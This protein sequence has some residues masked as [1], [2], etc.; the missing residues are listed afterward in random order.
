MSTGGFFGLKSDVHEVTKL[1]NDLSLRE[2]LEGSYKCPTLGKEKG[3][4]AVNANEPIMQSV[5]KVCSMRQT[6]KSSKS[7]NISDLDISG[8]KKVCSPFLSSASLGGSGIDGDCGD[9]SSV[10]LASSNEVCIRSFMAFYALVLYLSVRVN[11]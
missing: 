3:K 11:L 7:L 10:E 9:P 6:V 5:R 4:K 8:D 2:I 1:V